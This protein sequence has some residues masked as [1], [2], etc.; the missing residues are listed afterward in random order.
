MFGHLLL[1]I[2]RNTNIFLLRSRKIEVE[3]SQV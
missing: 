2:V 1:F 3:I